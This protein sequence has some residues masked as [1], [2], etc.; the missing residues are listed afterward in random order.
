[1]NTALPDR[2]A[3][4]PSSP[5]HSL[6]RRLSASADPAPPRKRPI[7]SMGMLRKTIA[8]AYTRLPVREPK[9]SLAPSLL[10]TQS[11]VP[12]SFSSL[13]SYALNQHHHRCHI[14]I[15][16]MGRSVEGVMAQGNKAPLSV[17]PPPHL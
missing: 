5:R 1:V 7:S 9:A 13:S 11:I 4:R 8:S 15:L 6:Y 17:G 12:L 2:N 3:L 14:V 16:I 10:R